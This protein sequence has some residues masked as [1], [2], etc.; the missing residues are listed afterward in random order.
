MRPRHPSIPKLWLMTDERMGDGLWDALERLP[1]GSGVVFRHYGVEADERQRIFRKVALIAQRRR[2]L[3]VRAGASGEHNR[4][5]RTFTAAA[6]S[7]TEAIAAIRAG[8]RLVFVSPVFP[9]RSHPGARTLG[10]SR[11]GLLI[12]G[13]KTPVVALGGMDARKARSLKQLGIH[14]WAA[15]DA[16]TKAED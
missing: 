12:R 1:R 9:T 7:R 11:L 3:L 8:A 15:I 10:K 4:R 6:H 5:A 2:L 13:L 16:W 14:G